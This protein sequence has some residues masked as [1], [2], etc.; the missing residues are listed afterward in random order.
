M[1]G[2]TSNA[3]GI[4]IC[5][6]PFDELPENIGRLLVYENHQ[7]A[8][9]RL[10]DNKIRA[11]ANQ[12]PHKQGPLVDGLV[13]GD[14]VFCPLHDWKIHMGNGV[15]QA[16]DVGCVHSYPAVVKD[17]NVFVSLPESL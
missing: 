11:I 13:S 10:G 5:A 4:E 15:V 16:P 7:I 12:C 6:G 2:S 3:V 9:F 14:F 17:G 1:N 8:L